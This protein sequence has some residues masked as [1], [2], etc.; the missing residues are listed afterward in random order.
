MA[1]ED[2]VNVLHN[3]KATGRAKLVL[4]GIANH[5][6]ENGAWPSIA[7]LAKYANAS[8][9][10]V[11]RDLQELVELGELEIDYQAAP[12]RGQYKTNVYYLTLSGVTDSSSGVTTQVSMGDSSGNSGVTPVGTLNIIKKPNRTIKEYSD[13]ETRVFDD[14]FEEFW[15]W[16]PRKTG[17]GA[18]RKAYEKAL[19]KRNHIALCDAANR[20][21][22]DPNLPEPQ[23]IP[24]PA[25][26]LNEER[27]DDEPYAPRK[28]TATKQEKNAEAATRFLEAFK[29]P[30][31]EIT[32]NPDWA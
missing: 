19:K 12:N 21:A 14:A 31:H 25:T 2:I 24:H 27:W 10:S 5:H 29:T 20:L 13:F 17:K 15:S 6:S 23:F 8:E 22:S 16:Y 26:W 7:T 18:A 30:T 28:T 3:S 1:I 32:E 4:I 11:K 9:R